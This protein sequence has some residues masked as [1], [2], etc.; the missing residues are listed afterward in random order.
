MAINFR[1]FVVDDFK[2]SGGVAEINRIIEDLC[3]KVS[4]LSSPRVVTVADATSITPN[5][6]IMD[7]CNQINTQSTGTLTVNAPTG[8]PSDGQWLIIRI[9][10]T[11]AQTFSFNSIYRGSSDLG[12]ATTT[13]ASSKTDYLG[14]RYNS[15]ATKWDYLAKT[16]GF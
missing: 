12:L 6:D 2:I 10:S 4:D 3:N 5:A 16:F 13:T 8:S 9:K 11:N 1:Q 7:I 15:A 14:F